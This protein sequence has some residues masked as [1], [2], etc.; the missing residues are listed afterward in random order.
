MEIAIEINGKTVRAER[1]ETILE[2]LRRQGMSIPTLCHLP[3]LSPT[4]SCRICVVEVAG[5]QELLP[6]CSQRVE[7]GMSVRTHTPRLLEARKAIIEMLLA[8][9]KGECLH[10]SRNGECELQELGAAFQITERRYPY[11]QRQRGKDSSSEGLVLDHNKCIL[12]QRCVRTCAELMGITALDAAGRG[13][14]TR[15]STT[16]D[17]GLNLS[18]CIQCGQCTLVCPTGALQSRDMVEEVARLLSQRDTFPVVSLSPVCALTLGEALGARAGKDLSGILATALRMIGFR[19]VLDMSAG[20]DLYL[21]LT[22][23][24]V[25]RRIQEGIPSPLFSLA[26]PAW[27]QRSK[28]PLIHLPGDRSNAPSPRQLMS[29]LSAVPESATFTD[30]LSHIVHVSIEPCTARRQEL[31]REPLPPGRK[32]VSELVM[33]TRDLARLIRLFGID[34]NLLEE[35]AADDPLG[36]HSYAGKIMGMSGGT[37][38]MVAQMVEDQLGAQPAGERRSAR[39]RSPRWWKETSIRIGKKEYA[40]IAVNGLARLEEA[41]AQIARR[42]DIAFVEVMACP[43]GCLFGGGHSRTRDES[44]ARA[45]VKAL[46]DAHGMYRRATSAIPD[47][48]QVLRSRLSSAE[49]SYLLDGPR[50]EK[51]GE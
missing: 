31:L 41:L 35:Q 42:R 24:E 20:D 5:H 4:G 14:A 29:L 13:T 47:P 16:L 21:R 12:C 40:F 11:T 36:V 39:M 15:I 25:G 19:R 28:H 33:T 17:K 51:T 49:L 48:L 3:G 30:N 6:S 32:P 38:E 37:A 44:T 2:V 9:H 8:S 26:C 46:A 10:C 7:P 34:I 27:A 45:R 43:G 22:A 1:G 50:K 23:E 18:D